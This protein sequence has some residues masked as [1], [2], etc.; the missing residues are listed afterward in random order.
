MVQYETYS[1]NLQNL[2]K[3]NTDGL[4]TFGEDEMKSMLKFKNT[5]ILTLH[6]AMTYYSGHFLR[7]K[8]RRKILLFD[9][10]PHV[11]ESRQTARLKNVVFSF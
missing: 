8:I 5:I 10:L 1:Q 7:R 4:N 3:E 9:V 11:T 6:N 2:R